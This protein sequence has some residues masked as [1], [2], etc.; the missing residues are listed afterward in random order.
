[1]KI[2]Q[3][4]KFFVGLFGLGAVFILL[5]KIHNYIPGSEKLQQVIKK[6]NIEVNALFYSEETR[7]SGSKKAIEEKLEE[8]NRRK[9][10][11]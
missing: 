7:S 2:K 5:P 6:E 4:I 3:V 11:Q 9:K 10:K 1:M 8:I